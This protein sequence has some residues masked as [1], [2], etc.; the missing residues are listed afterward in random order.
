MCCLQSKVPAPEEISVAV[1]ELS[2]A[3]VARADHRVRFA[4][5]GAVCC[6]QHDDRLHQP[7][8]SQ[9]LQTGCSGVRGADRVPAA[10]VSVQLPQQLLP[11]GRADLLHSPGQRL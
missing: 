5:S 1:G 4:G 10:Q 2:V 6:V 8:S 11:A 9:H 7:S 3:D